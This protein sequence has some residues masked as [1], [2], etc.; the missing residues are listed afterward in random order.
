M[1]AAASL[2]PAD[3]PRPTPL[4]GTWAGGGLSTYGAY[5]IQITG[6]RV[7]PGFPLQTSNLTRCDLRG[8]REGDLRRC[9]IIDC[10]LPDWLRPGA[11]GITSVDTD[12]LHDARFGNYIEGFLR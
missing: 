5:G 2:P 11:E 10:Y 8:V 9:L 1:T 7:W 3:V 6:A 4:L 12:R